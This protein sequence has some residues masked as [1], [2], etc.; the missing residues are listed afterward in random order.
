ME[1]IGL[2]DILGAFIFESSLTQVGEVILL[3][4]SGLL[5]QERGGDF[6]TGYKP[7]EEMSRDMVEMLR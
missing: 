6:S 7:L 5:L 4:S 3:A 1:G 2:D